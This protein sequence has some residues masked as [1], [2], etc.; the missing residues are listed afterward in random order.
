[1]EPN[2]STIMLELAK[3]RKLPICFTLSDLTYYI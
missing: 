2:R 3:R 1:V